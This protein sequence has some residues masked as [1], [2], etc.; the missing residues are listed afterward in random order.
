MKKYIFVVEWSELF[1][2]CM[3][4]LC[5]EHRFDERVFAL[6]ELDACCRA[7]DKNPNGYGF[8][9]RRVG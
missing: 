2:D 8:F 4:A 7:S 1:R 5:E 3:G 6:D 9:A